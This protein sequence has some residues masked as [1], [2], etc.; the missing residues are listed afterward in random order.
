MPF[1][2]P[3]VPF[4]SYFISFVIFIKCLNEPLLLFSTL[5]AIFRPF[6]PFVVPFVPF[7]V[8]WSKPEW[9]HILLFS[10]PYH[11]RP[12]FNRL[13]RL[14]YSL[15][16][17]WSIS[18]RLWSLLNVHM[19]QNNFLNQL[20]PFFDRLCRLWYRLCRFC[21]LCNLCSLVLPIQKCVQFN[22][23]LKGY[24]NWT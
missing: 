18:Y 22:A 20:L 11:L 24:L 16:R 15:C 4:V 8:R 3:F 9:H 7:V 10:I 13:C 19:T 17:L 5:N 21:R 12:F 14:W 6:V 2:V 23:G 1:V